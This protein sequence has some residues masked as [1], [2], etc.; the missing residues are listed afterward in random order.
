[1]YVLRQHP[2][3]VSQSKT[4][5][6]WAAMSPDQMHNPLSQLG[7]VFYENDKIVICIHCKYALQPSGQTVS[8][9]L[10]EKHFVLT[11]DRADLNAFVGSLELQDPIRYRHVRIDH[12]PIRIL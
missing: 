2:S 1:M 7:L 3:T 5:H 4:S 8:K 10:V 6:D 12:Q 11:K 9:H